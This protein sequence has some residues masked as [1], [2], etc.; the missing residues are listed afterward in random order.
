MQTK[1]A[2][3]VTNGI[4]KDFGTEILVKKVDLSLL[5]TVALRGVEIRDHHKDTLIFVNKLRTSLVNAKRIIDNELQL[6]S[7]S[8]EGIYMNMKTYKG[9]E[10]DNLSIFVEQLDSGKPSDSTSTPFVLTSSNLYLENLNYKLI[11]ENTE[12]QIEFSAVSGGGSIQD[13]E[14]NGPNVSMKIKG[15]HFK[16]NHDVNIT[17]LT[18]DFSYSKTGMVFHNT[19][20]QTAKSDIN[21]EIEFSYDRENLSNFIELVYVDA[22]FTDSKVAVSD[23]KSF[24]NELDGEEI[25]SFSTNINGSLNNFYATNANMTSSSG[26][27]VLGDMTFINAISE[28]EGFVFTGSFD[29]VTAEYDKLKDILPNVL[30]KNLPKELNKL[31]NFTLEGITKISEENIEATVDIES[32]IGDL[33]TD[34]EV[35]EFDNI[36]KASYVGEIEFSYFDMGK[37][38]EDESLGEFSF[39]GYIDGKGFAIDNVNTSLKGTSSLLEFNGYAYTN[40]EVDGNYRNNEFDG[41]II[42]D[43][44]NFKGR[45]DGL[46]DMAGDL[47]RFDFRMDISYLDLKETNFYDRDSISEIKGILDLDIS[48]NTIDNMQGIANIKNLEYTNERA[49]HPFQQFLILSTVQDD[50]RKIR[51]DSDELLKGEMEGNFKFAELPYVAENALGAIFTNYKP[52][53][54]EPHQYLKFDFT[55]YNQLVDIFLPDISVAPNTKVRGSISGDENR[56][57]VNLSSPRIVAYGNAIDSLSLRSDNKN[58]LYNTFLSAKKLSSEYYEI[59]KLSLINRKENDTL[60]F[61]SIFKGGKNTT[62]DFN[63]DFYYT[64]NEQQKSVVGIEKSTF[65]YKDFRWQVN[66]NNDHNHKVTFDIAKNQYLFSDFTFDSY[67]QQIKFKGELRDSSYTNI[68][69]EFTNVDLQSFLPSIDS[70][71]LNGN[72]NGTIDYLKEGKKH[73]PKGILSVNNFEI[74]TYPQGDLDLQITGNESFTNYQVA[75]NLKREGAKSITSVGKIDFSGERPL[76]DMQVALEDFQLDAFGPLGQDV[77]SSVR[78]SASGSFTLKGYFRNPNMDGFLKLKNAGL[79]FPYLNVDFDFDEEAK[80]GLEGQSFV[81]ENIGLEDVKY[82]TKGILDGR[83]THQNFDDWFLNL[84]ITSN[85]LLVLDTENSEEALYYGTGFIDGKASITG[86]TNSLTIDVVAKTNENTLFVIPLKDVT[87]VESYKLI[88][89]ISEEKIEDRQKELA[90]EAI[91]G[92]NLNIDL[93]VTKDATAEVVIDEVNGSN[94]EGSGAGNLRIEINTRGKFNM[95]GDFAIDNG[96]YNF[97]YG[98]VINKPFKIVKGGTISWIGDPYEAN[99]DI[100]AIYTTNANPGVLLEN[101]NTSRKIPVNLI[102][103]ISGGLFNSTQEFDIEIPNTDSTISSELDFVLNDNDVNSK[104]RQFLYLLTLGSFYNEN[105]NNN[106]GSD[107]LTGTTSNIIGSV[108]SDIISSDD[109]T[110]QLG[111]NYTQGNNGEDIDNLNTD[112][113]VDVSVTTQISDR[114]II[115]GKVGVPVGAQ[116]QSSVV[117]EVK[118]EVLLNEEGNFRSVI[119]NR[120]NEIQYSNEE[121][122]YTQGVGL[123]YQVNFNTLSDLL[124]KVGLKKKDKKKEKKKDSI[125]TRHPQLL[126]FKE[127]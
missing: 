51:I 124:R 108:V 42:V 90:I 122:G 31:G 64:I 104:M 32:E 12:K 123:S 120:Q 74:N 49:S 29:E 11:D 96:F 43:D 19:K 85:N 62:E 8:F 5:G 86:L 118:V 21:A 73:S 117:G 9:E 115:N 81:L 45:F 39:E 26:I 55:V 56:I 57:R 16:D 111:V 112:D 17:N 52:K 75:M 76:I 79:K 61:K 94:L 80:I 44:P 71:S 88:H 27:K 22:Q 47:N 103:T 54:V 97:K 58:E 121:E 23:L 37:F 24:Y 102:T 3:W 83:I 7:A 41:K 69:T 15:F 10:L 53:E 1:L 105:A 101:F 100:T 38:F 70:L 60:F 20:I 36:E 87:T 34:I 59:D 126:N 46:A 67:K 125:L 50:V 93:E 65:N 106:A 99:L 95:F 2:K 14:L 6:K 30:G 114:V 107:L 127:N 25:L 110:L 98:G 18:T 82:N 91:E 13:F 84:D 4:N 48:G 92:V 66:V 68:Q 113:Q 35:L 72:L 77:L 63:L 33:Y 78:G 40:L 116:T 28:E 109:G 119:F 89:F